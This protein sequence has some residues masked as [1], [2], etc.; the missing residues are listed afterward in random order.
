MTGLSSECMQYMTRP[1][2][3]DQHVNY[4]V[5]FHALL[6]HYIMHLCIQTFSSANSSAMPSD[7]D[8][9]IIILA[10]SIIACL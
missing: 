10:S 5:T 7:I 2:V 9:T 6:Y 4:D 1:Q 3:S 8:V